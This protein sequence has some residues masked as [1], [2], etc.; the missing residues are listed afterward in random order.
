MKTLFAWFGKSMEESPG[1]PSAMRVVMVLGLL[2]ITTVW[3]A[4]SL[5]SRTVIEIPQSVI[6]FA[7]LLIGGK[8]AQKFSENKTPPAPPVA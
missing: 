2:A 5:H 6:E 8:V 1:E 7:L 3:C 4:V